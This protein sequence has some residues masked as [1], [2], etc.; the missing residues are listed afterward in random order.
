MFAATDTAW[1]PW[2]VVRSDDK[3]RAQL[4]VISHLLSKIPYKHLP[5][6][7]VKLPKRSNKNAYDDQ[8]SLAERTA[9]PEK[10]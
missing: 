5:Q 4:N 6:E 10:F 2:Y 1:A 3:R 9:V 8:S 7:K